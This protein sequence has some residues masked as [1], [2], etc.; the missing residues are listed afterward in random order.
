[1]VKNQA[2]SSI[3]PTSIKLQN[4]CLHKIYHPY[5]HKIYHPFM[6]IFYRTPPPWFLWFCWFYVISSCSLIFS[7]FMWCLWFFVISLIP[8]Y[9]RLIFQQNIKF[10]ISVIFSVIFLIL[11]DFTLISVIFFYFKLTGRKAVCLATFGM[12]QVFLW[13]QTDHQISTTIMQHVQLNPFLFSASFRC[14][15]LSLS[16]IFHAL[17][18]C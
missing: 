18:K 12:E 10:I 6:H 1:M 13:W 16:G 3:H 9:F 17:K 14:I 8:I 7:D 5:M 2:S 15:T 4:P 11:T